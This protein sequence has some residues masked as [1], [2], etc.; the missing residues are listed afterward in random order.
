[1][2]KPFEDAAF[3][4]KKGEISDVVET[5]FGYHII[6]LTDVKAREKQRASKQVRAEIEAELKKQQAQKQ[7]RRGGRA[8]HQHRL[9]AVRQP[10]AGGRQ[11]EAEIKTAGH[12]ARA[13]RRPGAAGA[14][15]N[16]RSSSTPLF[17]PT[18]PC[19]TS[20]T[21]KPSRSAPNQLAS[22]RIV[23]VHARA[24]AAAGR[25]AGRRCA[26][27]LVAAAGRRAGAQGR[28]GASWRAWK[29][30]AGRRKLPGARDRSRVA[31]QAQ[32][33]RAVVDAALR[34]DPTKLPAA[35]G[36]R[37]RR[38]GLRRGAG[39]QGARAAM[40]RRRDAA[41]QELQPVRAGAGHRRERRPTTTR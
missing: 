22:G 21:P 35:A 16:R 38:A 19:A 3:A 5:E 8:V 11:A 28:R 31:R 12:R 20:A 18:R 27:R 17:A 34:A 2:V 41:E 9:R 15:A 33:R 4:M 29:A 23:A 6:Q 39:A 24:H 26:Q 14:L 40:P 10:E 32:R 36:R 37:P 1:M 30:S 25:G 13:R 7:V